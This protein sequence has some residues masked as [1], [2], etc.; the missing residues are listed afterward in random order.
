MNLSDD[1]IMWGA[2]NM[3]MK[4]HGDAAPVKV[5]ERIGELVVEGDM[6][7][8]ELWKGIARR[9]DAMINSSEAH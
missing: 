8:V 9:M 2:V 3:L 5:A 7:G 4:R 6:L 1:Q